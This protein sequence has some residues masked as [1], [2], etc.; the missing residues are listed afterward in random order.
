MKKRRVSLPRVSILA[1]SRRDLERFS[2][3][4]ESLSAQ[5]L[6]LERLMRN[7]E[8]QV[9]RLR[10]TGSKRRKAESAADHSAPATKGDDAYES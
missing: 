10:G 8:E 9:N 3:A 4:C 2:H 6:D 5:V 1:Y 7:L